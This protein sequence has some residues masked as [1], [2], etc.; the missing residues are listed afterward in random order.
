MCFEKINYMC[1]SVSNQLISESIRGIGQFSSIQLNNK[2]VICKRKKFR[3][4]LTSVKRH[5]CAQLCIEF[6]IF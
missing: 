2:E 5:S 3:T 4:S 6:T 1:L